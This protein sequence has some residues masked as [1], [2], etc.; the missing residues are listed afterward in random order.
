MR[1]R[2]AITLAL[3]SVPMLLAAVLIL[4]SAASPAA[5]QSGAPVPLLDNEIA[6][7]CPRT[8]VN[9][10]VGA[11]NGATFETMADGAVHVILDINP[12]SDS[13]IPGK[14][15][16]GIDFPDDVTGVAYVLEGDRWGVL[17]LTAVKPDSQVCEF[18]VQR[19]S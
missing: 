16:A 19:V 13:M 17:N 12:G 14:C 9:V 5:A 11:C 15:V 7:W 10:A 4:R 6:G 18:I 8:G 1:P 3:V 2:Y